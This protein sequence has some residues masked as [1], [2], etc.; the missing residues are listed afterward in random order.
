MKETSGPSDLKTLQSRAESLGIGDYM[1]I[2]RYPPGI[3]F[4]EFV[5]GGCVF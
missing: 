3:D 1:L 2:G 5:W 4:Q